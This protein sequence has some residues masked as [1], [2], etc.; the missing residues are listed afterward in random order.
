MQSAGIRVLRHEG[1]KPA[2]VGSTGPRTRTGHRRTPGQEGS[3]GHVPRGRAG[4]VGLR[5]W[6]AGIALSRRVLAGHRRAEARGCRG[7]QLHLGTGQSDACASST[8]APRTRPRAAQRQRPPGAPAR[9]HAADMVRRG[10][11]SH[12]SPEG[13]DLRR[14]AC[15]TPATWRRCSWS[16]GE[17]LAWGSGTESSPRSRVSAWMHSPPHRAVL[18]GR[19]FR[20]AGIGAVGGAPGNASARLDLRRGVRAPTLLVARS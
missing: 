16:A 7:A 11:F 3:C 5:V 8:R 17:T 19:A 10:Y 12:V 2:G 6:L 15:G 1:E 9:R 13:H 20:E 18:L 4:R 14:P